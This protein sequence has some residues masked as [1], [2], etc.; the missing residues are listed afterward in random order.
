LLGVGVGLITHPTKIWH[1]I[2]I[3]TQ[4]CCGND[5]G[6]GTAADDDDTL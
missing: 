4:G 3:K 1:E 5:D 6:N 2:Q